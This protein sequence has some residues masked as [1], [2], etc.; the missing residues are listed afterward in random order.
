MQLVRMPSEF[1]IADTRVLVTIKLGATA[2]AVEAA[3]AV[4]TGFR[5]TQN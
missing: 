1:S 2:T 5:N 4:R 3:T